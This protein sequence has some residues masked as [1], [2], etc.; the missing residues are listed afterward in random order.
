M[1]G[2]HSGCLW[3]NSP[4]SLLDRVAMHI[5][6]VSVRVQVAVEHE[7]S[8][9]ERAWVNKTAML[10]NAHLLNVEYIAT[11]EDLEQY[12]RLSSKDHD[13]LVRDLVGQSH[14]R[15]HPTS[16]VDARAPAYLLPNVPLDV[17]DFDRI[18]YSLLINPTAKCEHVL[19][20]ECA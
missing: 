5:H 2:K 16:L 13:F 14:V 11:V 3:N 19:V 1:F 9:H 15:G 6:V 7:R 4:L 12:R 10:T 17:V 18:Y 8:V 20:L